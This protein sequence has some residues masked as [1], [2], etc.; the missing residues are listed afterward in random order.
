MGNEAPN[1]TWQDTIGLGFPHPQL[2]TSSRR[3]MPATCGLYTQCRCKVAW[4]VAPILV[5]SN[6]NR[7]THERLSSPE[8]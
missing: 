3:R 7:I 8:G 6:T 5:G 1:H 2:L 4:P